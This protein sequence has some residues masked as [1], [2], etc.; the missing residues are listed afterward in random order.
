MYDVYS[1]KVREQK[2]RREQR[3]PPPAHGSGASSSVGS[4]ESAASTAVEAANGRYEPGQH[5]LD[6][7]EFVDLLVEP[8]LG[9][10]N[11]IVS[12]SDDG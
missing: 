2:R 8:Q 3:H 10:N 6:A 4:S 5:P 7:L 1:R 11:R 9:G 12:T